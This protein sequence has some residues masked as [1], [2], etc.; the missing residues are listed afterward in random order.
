MD[1]RLRGGLPARAVGV[2]V[3]AAKCDCGRTLPFKGLNE[4]ARSFEEQRAF[5]RVLLFI[6]TATPRKLEHLG[7]VLE[8]MRDSDERGENT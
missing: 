6:G 7:K 2:G 1:A 4:Y 5:E 3:S 8:Q